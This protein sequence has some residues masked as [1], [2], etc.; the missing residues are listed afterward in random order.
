MIARSTPLVSLQ[1]PGVC[2]GAVCVEVLWVSL[3]L[4]CVE[5][6]R[7]WLGLVCVATVRT[8]QTKL[9][10]RLGRASQRPLASRGRHANIALAVVKR[11]RESLQAEVGSSSE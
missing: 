7:L 3:G 5:V 8:C 9:R 10:L 1:K 2:G 6:W 11:K 4:V